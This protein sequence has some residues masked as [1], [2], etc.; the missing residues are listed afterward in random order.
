MP[1]FAFLYHSGTSYFCNDSQSGRNGPWLLTASTSFRRAARSRVVLAAGLLPD[2]IN[3]CGILRS[4]WSR[5]ALSARWRQALVQICRLRGVLRVQA[6]HGQDHENRNQK[7]RGRFLHLFSNNAAQ[8]TN[9]SG[10][11]VKNFSHESR[12][13]RNTAHAQC[14]IT[15]QM[16][17]LD[18]VKPRGMRA[19]RSRVRAN[20]PGHR[21]CH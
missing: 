20:L 10:R 8:T 9:K 21:A 17:R 14:P 15:A 13:T 12:G 19:F 16:P 7:S 4:G 11:S 1:N 6:A 18:F 5:R 3:L 2:L